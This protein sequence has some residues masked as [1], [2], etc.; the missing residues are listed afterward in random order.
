M[1]SRRSLA[2]PITLTVLASCASGSIATT[3]PTSYPDDDAS[4]PNRRPTTQDS[5]RPNP[6][7]DATDGNIDVPLVDAPLIDVPIDEPTLPHIDNFSGSSNSRVISLVRAA[8]DGLGFDPA[9][10]DGPNPDDRVFVGKFYIAWIDQTGFYGKM[11]GLFPLNGEA[12]DAL[13]FTLKDPDGRPVN[14]FVPGEDGEGR[15]PASYKGAEH[16]EFPSRVPEPNDNRPCGGGGICNWYSLNEAPLI[17]NPAIPWWQS[18]NPGSIPFT[19]KIHPLGEKPIPGGLKLVYEGPLV[20]QADGQSPHIGKA[21]HE[22]ELFPDGVRRPVYVQL[23]YELHADQ[24]YFDRTMQIRNDTGNPPF[25]GDMSLIGGFVM[26]TWPNPHYLKRYNR[27]W[28]PEQDA[29][30]LNWGGT[31]LTLA[32]GTWNDLHKQPTLTSDA[33]IGWAAQPITLGATSAYASGRTAQV[34]NMGPSDNDDVGVCLCAVHGG[35]EM[36]GGLIHEG[37]SLPVDGGGT[38]IEAKR[39]LTLPMGAPG[40]KV[41]GITFGASTLSHKIGRAESGG[42][43]ANT[44]NDQ[45]NHMAYGP[46]ATD[47][48][49]G[50]VQGVFVLM[51]DNNTADN[52]EVVVLEVH[53]ADTDENVSRRS[54]ARQQFRAPFQY[55]R[56]TVNGD[57]DGRAGHKME[58]RLWWS[59]TS[60]VRLD[61][62]LVHTSEY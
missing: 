42:W 59:G 17:T 46:Y 14:M 53:D 12:L 1:R 61:K 32:P 8:L 21:C 54:I 22:N 20:K 52:N 28:R 62:V 24:P 15:W 2:I 34:A 9:R 57:L 27:F 45:P 40:G 50:S 47:W 38:T 16:I 23:G 56:F 49:G 41:A 5:G 11:N 33:L 13:D 60:Y 37:I 26:T 36:G 10:G 29:V 3:S 43:S 48:G 25:K 31:Q 51:V 19:Q 39:R 18:C 7:D 30:K 6:R 55:Q 58:M 4:F 44:T 35:I